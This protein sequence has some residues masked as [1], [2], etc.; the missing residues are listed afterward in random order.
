MFEGS[1]T[2]FE[3]VVDVHK[4]STAGIIT[5]TIHKFVNFH[6]SGKRPAEGQIGGGSRPKTQRVVR[7][8]W[9]WQSLNHTADKCTLDLK[10]VD[11]TPETILNVLKEDISDLKVTIEEELEKKHLLKTL[12]YKKKF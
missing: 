8:E 1:M 3:D 5:S 4:P 7:P 11:Q 12:R 9:R 6:T 2:V 10:K